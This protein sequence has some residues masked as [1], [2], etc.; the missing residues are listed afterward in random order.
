L[1]SAQGLPRLALWRNG[2]SSGNKHKLPLKDRM[3]APEFALIPDFMNTPLPRQP[4]AQNLQDNTQPG[5]CARIRILATSDLHMHLTGHDYYADRTDMRVGFTRTATLIRQARQQALQQDALVLLFD[6][7]DALQGTPFGQWA[8]EAEQTPH[9]LP[10]AFAAL[11]YDAVGLGNHDCG[12]GFEFLGRIVAQSPYPVLC[13]NMR[14]TA[15]QNPW[16]PYAILSRP[17]GL[18][19]ED[20]PIRIGVFSVLPPQTAQWEAHKLDGKAKVA[21]ILETARDVAADLR[22]QGCDLVVALA[23]TG[24]GSSAAAPGLENAVIPLAELS[25]LDAIIAGHT[26]LT[27]PGSAHEVLDHVNRASGHA[28]GKPVVTPG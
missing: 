6:N 15:N 2:D 26:H 28:H 3:T 14:C 16:Q 20:A 11:G 10:Q 7:G 4:E 19:G 17:I 9:P 8:A 5:P 25:G 12:F 23:H 13:S 1:S 27:L 22:Q 21:D 18:N 24:L